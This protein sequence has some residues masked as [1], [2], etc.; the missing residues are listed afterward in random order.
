MSGCKL[1]IIHVIYV[2]MCVVE[3]VSLSSS[4]KSCIMQRIPALSVHSGG[5]TCLTLRNDMV[6]EVQASTLKTL[7]DSNSELSVSS[8]GFWP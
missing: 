8:F 5:I 6:K 1:N 2:C 4:S 3:C 7:F